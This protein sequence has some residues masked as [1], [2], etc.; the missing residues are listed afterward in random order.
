MATNVSSLV[1]S[2]RITRAAAAKDDPV[3][4]G[5][6]TGEA[7]INAMQSSPY[8]DTNVEPEREPMPIRDISL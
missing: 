8:H 6:M 7:L 3:S 2:V 4:E 5:D 1:F